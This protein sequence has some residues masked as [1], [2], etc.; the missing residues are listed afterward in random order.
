M[1]ATLRRPKAATHWSARRLAREV[2]LSRA[3]VHRIWQKYG[4]QP[5]RTEHFKFSTDPQFDAK[6]ADIV[7]ALSRCARSRWCCAWTRNRKFRRSTAPSQR[8][9]CGRTCR[10]A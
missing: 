3:S 2:G 6:L 10:R 7:G 8:C 1:S 5:H 4:L 9:R